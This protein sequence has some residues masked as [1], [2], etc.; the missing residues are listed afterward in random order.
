MKYKS[1]EKLIQMTKDILDKEYDLSKNLE[2]VLG[3]NGGDCQI[4]MSIFSTEIDTII[5]IIAEEVKM[6]TENAIE[7][8]EYLVYEV[9]FNENELTFESEDIEYVANT[10][11][12]WKLINL[13]L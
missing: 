11:N 6:S 3:K 1:F 10:K 5:D 4:I 13:E 7:W 8:I 12:I 9:Y 2:N